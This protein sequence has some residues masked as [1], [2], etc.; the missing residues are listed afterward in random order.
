M[1][2]NKLKAIFFDFDGVLVE[3]MGIKAEAFKYLFRNNTEHVKEI[4]DLH[5]KH[6]GMSRFE[7]FRIIYENVLKLPFNEKISEALNEKFSKFVYNRVIECPFVKGAEEFLVKY[8]KRLL[9]FIVS[10]TPQH[11][12][13]NIAKA[14]KMN[15]YFKGIFGSPKHKNQL[16]R[17]ILEEFKI[18]LKN[19]LLIGDS[20]ED[21]EAAK[22]NRIKFVGRITEKGKDVFE[23]LS[24]N[25]VPD[26]IGFESMLKKESL[27]E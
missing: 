10:G 26:I 4:V 25:T 12:M 1:I 16:V 8:H 24:I 5:M 19:V 6:G 14:R 15:K 7:K 11:E 2:K 18:N 22:K 13:R 21:Y 23:N 9:F 20:I 3:S 17:E 27:L